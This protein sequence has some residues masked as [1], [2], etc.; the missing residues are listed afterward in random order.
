[1]ST[2]ILK[3]QNGEEV[4]RFNSLTSFINYLVTLNFTNSSIVELLRDEVCGNYK[5]EVTKSDE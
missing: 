2:Y 3:L 1:M 5:L 4:G